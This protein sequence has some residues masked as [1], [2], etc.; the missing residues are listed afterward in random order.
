MP[1]TRFKI[2]LTLCCAGFVTACQ[3]QGDTSRQTTESDMATYRATDYPVTLEYDRSLER[4]D[5][6]PSGYFENG[7][8]QIA[9]DT[10]G[11]RLITLSLPESN[12]LATGLW[13]LGASRDPAAVGACL[14]PPPNARAMPSKTTIGGNPFDGFTLGD[15]GM[16]HF[17]S[18]EGYRAVIDETCYAIDLIVQG[19]NG[20]VYDPPRKA[21]FSRGEALKQLEIINDGVSF[22]DE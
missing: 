3:Q 5:G 1:R 8:W 10:P 2:V 20:E 11:K 7:S 19:T 21:P 17:Q 6:D 4:I 22:S 9:D 13:R 14:T 15:A 12:D 18:I 16:N